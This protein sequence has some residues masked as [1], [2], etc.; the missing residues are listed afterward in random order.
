MLLD[1]KAE[2]EEDLESAK[3]DAAYACDR[4][5]T[6]YQ[7]KARVKY[8]SKMR[9]EKLKMQQEENK[10]LQ[11]EA[12]RMLTAKQTVEGLYQSYREKTLSSRKEMKL[13][14]KK[15]E[16]VVSGQYE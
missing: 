9:L 1:E 6:L 14:R 4:L 5:K 10:W 13:Q 11:D 16:V 2:L 7:H 12:V 8:T 3:L 15:P